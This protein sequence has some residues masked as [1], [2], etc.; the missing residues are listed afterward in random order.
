MELELISQEDALRKA[1]EIKELAFAIA[2][3]NGTL[4]G[5]CDAP[6]CIQYCTYVALATSLDLGQHCISLNGQPVK[7]QL[8][9]NYFG[10]LACFNLHR[11][12]IEEDG[13]LRLEYVNGAVERYIYVEEIGAWKL[14]GRNLPIV[15][16]S[17]S[18][19]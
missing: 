10:M 18:A 15:V 13:S 9:R 19:N 7:V 14:E 16:P 6:E 12:S 3:A 11:V 5:N 2:A 4:P 8:G 17:S 1:S